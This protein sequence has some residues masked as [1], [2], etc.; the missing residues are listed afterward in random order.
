[1]A[2]LRAYLFAEAVRSLQTLLDNHVVSGPT[3]VTAFS[4][5]KHERDGTPVTTPARYVLA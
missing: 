3:H 1:M 2:D 4:V 5:L